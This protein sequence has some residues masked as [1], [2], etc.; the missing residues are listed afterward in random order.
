MTQNPIIVALDVESAADA[1]ALVGRLGQ[2][3][4]FYKV[5]MELYAAAGMEFVRELVGE[6]KDVFLDLKMYDIPET[7]KRAVAQVARTG[8]RFLTI[9]AVGSAMRAAVEGRGDSGLKLLGVTVLTS[10]GPED[11]DDLNYQGSIADLVERRARKAVEVGMDGI[12]ASPLEVSA[13]RRIAGPKT[14]LVIPGIR[15]AANDKGD[16]KRVSTPAEAMAAGA[17]YLVIGRQITRA[18]DPAAEAAKVLAEI[19]VAG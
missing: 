8:V 16:Q 11:M 13:V 5:G 7:V 14:I 18:A 12:V 17:D 6:G 15:S 2:H 10:F 19:C 1:R 3:V 4:N 9:H